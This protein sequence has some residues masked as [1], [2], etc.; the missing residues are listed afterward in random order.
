MYVNLFMF[1]RGFLF[2]YIFFYI[3]IFNT[4]F[5]IKK[6]EGNQI[7]FL[8]HKMFNVFNASIKRIICFNNVICILN[9]NV[10]QRPC[11]NSSTSFVSFF[12]FYQLWLV[13]LFF[14]ISN[15]LF[16]FGWFHRLGELHEWNNFLACMFFFT[17]FF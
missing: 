4:H 16:S 14:Y 12:L 3:S 13:L 17:F 2:N 11:F 15:V 9:W 10:L 5:I 7:C 1:C 8:I 6:S